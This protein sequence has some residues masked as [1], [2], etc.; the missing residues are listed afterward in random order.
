MANTNSKNDELNDELTRGRPQ[1]IGFQTAG[2]IE[3]RLMVPMIDEMGSWVSWA[4]PTE[5]E[6]AA[7]EG[8]R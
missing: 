5:R 7:H 8:R 6:R 3:Q 1:Q 2:K 4:L